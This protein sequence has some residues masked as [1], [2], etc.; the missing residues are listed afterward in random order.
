MRIFPAVRCL[1]FRE[2]N[3]IHETLRNYR[4]APTK[5][6]S[7]A[8]E[9]TQLGEETEREE[10]LNRIELVETVT[11]RADPGEEELVTRWEMEENYFCSIE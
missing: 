8:M 5:T 11:C 1:L 10:N 9:M 2:P 3:D 7:V 6:E 4:L